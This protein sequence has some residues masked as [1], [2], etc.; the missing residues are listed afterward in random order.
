MLN[1]ANVSNK[2]V[3]DNKVSFCGLEY[4]LTDKEATQLK[5]ILDGMV[6]S[7][8]NT[9]IGTGSEVVNDSD[10]KTEKQYKPVNEHI[11]GMG[12]KVEKLTNADDSKEYYCIG[13]VAPAKFHMTKD[14]RTKV[15]AGI[16]AL[17]KIETITV[18]YTDKNG[19]AKQY[20]AWGYKT[21]ATAEKKLSTLATSFD[22]IRQELVK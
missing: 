8:G 6:G 16:K 13:Y 3:A 22:Y 21:K 15:N 1:F 19:V 12:Y 4:L 14:L 2:V 18:K 17:D 9:V 7:R 5:G 11:D 20:K 10:S